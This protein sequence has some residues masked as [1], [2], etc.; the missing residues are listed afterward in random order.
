L[1]E[2][3]LTNSKSLQLKNNKDINIILFA[4]DQVLLA[5]IDDHLHENISKL[6]KILQLYENGA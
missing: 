2:W 4:D 1:E 6:Y 3:K 5:G